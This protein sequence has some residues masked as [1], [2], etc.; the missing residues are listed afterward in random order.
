MQGGPD[1]VANPLWGD[2]LV[3]T[4]N[5]ICMEV[6]KWVYLEHPLSYIVL[7]NGSQEKN[8]QSESS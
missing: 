3:H 6:G 5:K 1:K 2:C 7:K 4:V 8:I